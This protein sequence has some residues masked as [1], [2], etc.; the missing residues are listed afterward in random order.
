[1]A[2]VINIFDLTT[3]I[4]IPHNIMT[5]GKTLMLQLFDKNADSFNVYIRYTLF[6]DQIPGIE[7][8]EHW[9]KF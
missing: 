4:K 5:C 2:L 8:L 6:L 7:K 1:M 3:L 9:H